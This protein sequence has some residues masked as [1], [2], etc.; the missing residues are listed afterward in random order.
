MCIRDRH[1]TTYFDAL[2]P[3]TTYVGFAA[4]RLPRCKTRPSPVL[5]KAPSARTIPDR[6]PRIL[7]QDRVH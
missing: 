7:S 2:P 4:S 1:P 6:G 3:T 5:Q